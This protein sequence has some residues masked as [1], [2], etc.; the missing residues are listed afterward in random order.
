MRIAG[1]AGLLVDPKQTGPRIAPEA[2]FMS[3]LIGPHRPINLAER[4]NALGQAREFAAR[5][6]L[7][8]DSAG[9]AAG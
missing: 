7:V 3:L 4:G 9:Y 2:R 8:D 6:V 5:R 1:I